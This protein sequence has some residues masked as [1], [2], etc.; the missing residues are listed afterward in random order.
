MAQAAP[1]RD[2]RR[3]AAARTSAPEEPMEQP[4]QWP[5]EDT[6]PSARRRHPLRQA[7]PVSA[8]ELAPPQPPAWRRRFGLL[9]SAVA[10]ALILL[11]FVKLFDRQRDGSAT[12]AETAVGEQTPTD[13]RTEADRKTL[14]P[15]SAKSAPAPTVASPAADASTQEDQAA[16]AQAKEE[17]AA[18]ETVGAGAL[19]A[20]KSTTPVRQPRIWR[21]PR[22][23][24]RP[25]AKAPAAE[26]ATK[27][28]DKP[29][30]QLPPPPPKPKPKRGTIVRE[31]PF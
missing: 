6:A 24:S 5:E 9:L 25:K 11:G 18:A 31:T 14:D 15:A 17:T 29:A 23:R 20:A 27:A 10:G 4:G 22:P 19:P 8:A 3:V 13:T 30:P 16:E 7:Q 2:E 26:R 28:A 1:A 12:P 21:R